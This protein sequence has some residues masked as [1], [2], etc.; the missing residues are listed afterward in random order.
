M[1][2]FEEKD[3]Q[4]ARNSADAI[5]TNADNIL[6]IFDSIDSAM[7]SLYGDAWQSTGADVSNG[8]YQ[9]IR[10]NYEVFYNNVVSMRNHIY[11]VTQIN[12]ETDASV[13]QNIAGI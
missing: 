6:G 12:E 1:N 8:R 5:K 10:T 7:K 11:T 9:E 3:Y 13:S 4:G 2:E